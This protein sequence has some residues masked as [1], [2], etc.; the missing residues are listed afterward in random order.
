[1]KPDPEKDNQ[2]A[3]SACQFVSTIDEYAEVAAALEQTVVEAV[4][5]IPLE[6]GTLYKLSL[7][8]PARVEVLL[9]DADLDGVMFVL[10][11]ECPNAS[12]N[13][14]AWGHEIC[15]PAIAAGD[16][17]LAVFSE[18]YLEFSFSVDLLPPEESCDGLDVVVDC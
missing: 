7:A 17:V 13:R 4:C 12:V 6:Y 10:L 5:T 8:A 15:S 16:Y 1:V 11:S 18:R 2:E 3:A 14:I 9:E